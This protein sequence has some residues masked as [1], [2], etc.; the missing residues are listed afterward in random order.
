MDD[1]WP[2]SDLSQEEERALALDAEDDLAAY[3]ER[4]HLPRL[5]DGAPAVYFCGNSLGLQPVGTEAA[6]RNELESWARLGVEA[7]FEGSHP[8]YVYPER[9]RA[10]H[11]ALVGALPDETV[12]MNGLTVNLHLMLVSFYRPDA[13]RNKV[14]MEACAFPSDS[15]AVASHLRLHGLDPAETLIVVRPRPGESV[16]RDEDLDELLERRGDEIALVLLGGVNYFTG[17][18]FD[19]ERITA[20]ARERGCVV[21]FDL[22]HAAGNVELRLHDWGVDFAVWCTY[23]YLNAGPGA[24]AG[25]FVHQRHGA[26]ASLPRLAG[27]WGNDPARRFRMHLESEFQPFAGAAGWQVSNPPVLAL[28]PLRVSLELFEEVGMKRLRAKSRRLTGYLQQWIDAVGDRRL[29][30]LTPAEPS[31]RGCQISM[32]VEERPR[33]LFEA[34]RGEGVIG[35]YREP[36]VVRVAPA[37]LYNTF[38]EVWRFGQ[39]L[40]AWSRAVG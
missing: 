36:D 40:R 24:V 4:F 22:A 1:S 34:L 7:H 39:A 32:R 38:H 5:P 10:T 15:Y 31:A 26:A 28:A 11:G 2:T 16:I 20:R 8:W 37:P 14:L 19:M 23:K 27:W 29:V 3:R 6:V 33:E 25:C 21:G 12:V 17:Q 35:D 18:L 9:L 30:V 13:G